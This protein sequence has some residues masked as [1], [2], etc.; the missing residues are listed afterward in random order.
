MLHP[1]YTNEE[2]FRTRFIRPLLTRLGYLGVAEL[3]GAHEFGKDFVFAEIT[4]FGFL[5][6]HAAVVKH[7]ASINQGKSVDDVLTQIRQAFNVKFRLSD[8]PATHGVSS[9]YVFNSGNI[10]DN[11]KHQIRDDLNRERYGENVH[12]FDSERLQQLDLTASY[13]DQRQYLP[14]IEGLERELKL[15]L[16]VWQS[17]LNE[18][19]LFREARGSFTRAMEEFLIAPLP[20]APINLDELMSLLQACRIIDGI[21][22]RYFNGGIGFKQEIRDGDTESLRNLIATSTQLSQRLLVVVGKAKC[23]FGPLSEISIEPAG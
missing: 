8:S 11:A 1:T 19:P 23:G 20:A 2:D 6:Y 14:R 12:I 21:Y 5:K 13:R 9:V 22:F 17:M 10:T 7:Q 15:N 3:H 4:P 16:Y 18:F